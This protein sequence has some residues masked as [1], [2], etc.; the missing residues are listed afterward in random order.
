MFRIQTLNAIAAAGLSQFPVETYEVAS[1]MQYPDAILLR[2]H[3]MHESIIPDSVKAIGRA[4]AGVNNIPV[5]SLTKLGIP[6]FNTPGA[7]ANAVRELVIAGMLLASRNIC[8][9]WQYVNELQSDGEQ[10]EKEVEQGKKQFVGFELL[11]KT[12]GVIGLGSVGVKVANAAI[13]LGMRVIGYDPTISVN[14]AWELSANVQQAYSI[15]DLLLEADFISFHV[16]LMKETKNMINRSRL[17][18]IKQGA[19][20]LN[21]AREG[22]IEN[23][24][25][26]DAL[27]A[28]KI[29][30]YVSDFPC[31]QLKNHPAVISLQHLLHEQKRNAVYYLTRQFHLPL[32]LCVK[33][34]N[35]VLVDEQDPTLSL[36]IHLL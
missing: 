24:A 3:S 10:L 11:G 8:Q 4:G 30:T 29:F 25:L 13:N 33:S 15:D 26:Y 19:V 31:A 6:V 16:P 18:I 21:F 22:I 23:Q 27:N 1:E 9:A 12:L 7:N 20:I 2:S 17:Q 32:H 14:R 36:L 28:G 35:D 34:L 5:D